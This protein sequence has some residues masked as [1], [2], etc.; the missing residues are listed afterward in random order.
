MLYSLGS[1]L[2]TETIDPFFTRWNKNPQTDEFTYPEAIRCLKIETCRPTS[3]KKRIYRSDSDVSR[4][5]ARDAEPSRPWHLNPLMRLDTPSF[6]AP[7][8]DN[9]TLSVQWRSQTEHV[10]GLLHGNDAAAGPRSGDEGFER[11]INTKNFLRA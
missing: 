11:V 7:R 3:E 2:S 5:R 4:A 8:I 10:T 1:A 9:V 6:S